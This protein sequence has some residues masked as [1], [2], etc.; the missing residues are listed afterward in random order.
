[1][2]VDAPEIL[3]LSIDLENCRVD[4]SGDVGSGARDS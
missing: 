2:N 4:S 1:L 3:G